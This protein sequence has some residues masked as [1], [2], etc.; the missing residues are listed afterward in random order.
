MRGI[1]R[2]A[3]GQT[4]TPMQ[5]HRLFF[6][7]FSFCPWV[8][9]GLQHW[10]SWFSCKDISLNSTKFTCYTFMHSM[11]ETFEPP[12]HT[13]GAHKSHN[14]YQLQPFWWVK[15][16]ASSWNTL[17]N[18]AKLSLARNSNQFMRPSQPNFRKSQF[19]K[20]YKREHLIIK[21]I[22]RITHM[23][24]DG[25]V[26]FS[27]WVQDGKVLSKWGPNWD[28]ADPAC[29]VSYFC[30]LEIDHTSGMTLHAGWVWPYMQDILLS[31]H[32]QMGPSKIR[33]YIRND[34]TSYIIVVLNSH[35]VI[36]YDLSMCYLGTWISCF[37]QL[38]QIQWSQSGHPPPVHPVGSNFASPKINLISASWR[39]CASTPSRST[40]TPRRGSREWRRTN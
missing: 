20:S 8:I 13:V 2:H 26:A 29:K 11:F 24:K 4:H 21:W 5:K 32:L 27:D 23:N 17:F 15:P 1:W 28:A 33:T 7:P 9:A 36:T 16:F 18:L 39:P 38:G 6:S 14:Y 3:G 37:F 34:L 19:Q 40:P 10:L 25:E 35:R 22:L 12:S 30:P 31:T